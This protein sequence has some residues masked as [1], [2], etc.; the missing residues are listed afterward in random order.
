MNGIEMSIISFRKKDIS[1]NAC[2]RRP[3]IA[4]TNKLGTLPALNQ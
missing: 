3:G 1:D 4:L 2:Q